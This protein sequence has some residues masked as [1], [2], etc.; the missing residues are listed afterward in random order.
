MKE[1][2]P[3]R[4][5][6]EAAEEFQGLLKSLPAIV[7]SSENNSNYPV[8]LLTKGEQEQCSNTCAGSRYGFCC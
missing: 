1:H 8:S 6:A 5:S 3:F 2:W 7:D 4:V